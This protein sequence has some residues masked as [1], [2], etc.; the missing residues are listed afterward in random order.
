MISAKRRHSRLTTGDATTIAPLSK[1]GT[2]IR[3][4]FGDKDTR[5]GS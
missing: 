3:R 5:S 1:F 2:S 4:F